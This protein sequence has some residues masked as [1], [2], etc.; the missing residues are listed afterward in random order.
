M[1]QI[2][3]YTL[4]TEGQ[5]PEAGP[6]AGLEAASVYGRG[7]ESFGNA[8]QEGGAAITRA[9]TQKDVSNA[10]SKW[11][12][13]RAQK[14]AEINQ[15]SQDG[16]LDVDK[17]KQDVQD[18]TDKNFDAVSTSQ[19]KDFYNRQAARVGNYLLLHATQQ[20]A[21]LAGRQAVGD[22]NQ[23]VAADAQSFSYDP[24]IENY[25]SAMQGQADSLHM[26]VTGG[27]DQYGN[28]VPG[29]IDAKDVPKILDQTNNTLTTEFIKQSASK[30]PDGTQKMIDD[31]TFDDFIKGGRSPLTDIVNAQRHM[32]NGQSA[33][34]EAEANRAKKAMYDDWGNKNIQVNPDGSVKINLSTINQADFMTPS[35]KLQ[36]AGAAERSAKQSVATDPLTANRITSMI[37]T[38]KITGSDQLLPYLNRTDGHGIDGKTYDYFSSKLAKTPQAEQQKSLDKLMGQDVAHQLTTFDGKTDYAAKMQFMMDMNNKQKQLQQQGQ[39]PNSIYDKK[40]ANYYRTSLL[41][42]GYMRSDEDKANEMVNK[43]KAQAGLSTDQ[44]PPPATNYT[45]DVSDYATKWNIPLQRAQEIKN[46]KTGVK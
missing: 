13:F 32:I 9:E 10:Y 34:D 7:I 29:G 33:Q 24:S 41:S 23:G 42:G 35:Q 6:S 12:T 38:G 43:I 22:F 21:I 17:V 40:S 44:S 31:G 2:Q 37:A 26:H 20:K 11:A 25:Q 28:D 1:P 14:T 39:D 15:G 27:K 46:S 18:F 36:V 5:Q 16:T 45:K 3:E 30:D 4:Q 8:L 19:G